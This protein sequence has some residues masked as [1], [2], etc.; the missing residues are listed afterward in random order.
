MLEMLVVMAIV[1]ILAAFIAPRIGGSIKNLKLRA[2]VRRCAAVLR[3]ARSIAIT[4]HQEQKVQ[5]FIK[6]D[7]EEN[8]YYSYTKVTRKPDNGSADEYA[9]DMVEQPES[10]DRYREETK[11]VVLDK[12]SGTISWRDDTED[13][14]GDEGNYEILF[15]PRGYNSG[16]E[17]R[18]ALS[19]EEGR[20][21][22]IMS[23]D[24][25]TGRVKVSREGE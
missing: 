2:Y 4:T 5:F 9:E 14:W 22:Y 1:A 24:P 23:I 18:F 21:A 11:E 7:P 12:G 20:R 25:I 17:I 15:T 16:G 19:E 6:E 10:K 8:D 13:T 3:Y